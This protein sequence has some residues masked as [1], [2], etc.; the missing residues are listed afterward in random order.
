MSEFSQR[1]VRWQRTHGRHGLPWQGGSAY[2]VW[3]SEVMLQQTQVATVIPY[4]LK[5][6]QAFPTVVELARA[7][8]D[9]VLS[10]WSGLGYYARGRNLHK[11]AQQV[12]TEHGGH[13]PED[14][15]QIL[16]LPGVGRS[17]A[18]AICA[19][20]YQQRYAILDGNV[21]RLLARY[22]GIEGVVT[23]SQVE[24]RLWQ[25]AEALLPLQ[26][27]AVYTQAQMDMGALICTRSRPHCDRCPVAG[28]CVALQTGR[29]AELPSRKPKKVLPQRQALFLLLR[30][31]DQLWL[32]KRPAP[33]IWGGL[34][35]FPQRDISDLESWQQAAA[36]YA[37]QQ[38]LSVCSSR[39]LNP[40]LHTFSHYRLHML[41]IELQLESM[42]LAV[43]QQQAGWFLPAQVEQ[44]GLPAPVARI[45]Q[46][47]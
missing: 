24:R 1:L 22:C 33:G 13:F 4:Y 2:Q 18:A 23:S 19:Q 14:F 10:L 41:P 43:S 20:A 35:C 47:G 17:T 44:L 39:K 30:Y 38:G 36:L 31:R 5:F 7:S 46:S 12:Q 27:I 25:Q 34:W 45:L 8:Q 28:Q 42:P 16:A 26:D 29:V 15:E 11:A 40:L 37:Q 6:I 32:E 21:K 3:L 9:S